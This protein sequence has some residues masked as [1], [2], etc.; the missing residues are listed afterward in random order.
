MAKLKVGTAKSPPLRIGEW[1]TEFNGKIPRHQTLDG[2]EPIAV[3]DAHAA[4]VVDR[5]VYVVT[6]LAEDKTKGDVAYELYVDLQGKI[7]V[8]EGNHYD[9]IPERGSS[10]VGEATHTVRLPRLNPERKAIW[11]WL[12]LSPFRLPKPAVHDLEQLAGDLQK[13]V[14]PLWAWSRGRALPGVV[15]SA[16]GWSL[17]ETPLWLTVPPGLPDQGTKCRVALGIDPFTLAE[18]RSRTYVKA[19]NR[20]K[21]EYEPENPK[22][23]SEY[24]R[25]ALGRLITQTVLG[26]ETSADKYKEYLD[27]AKLNAAMA[28]DDEVRNKRIRAS[29]EAAAAMVD[30]MDSRLFDLLVQAS[31]SDE[32]LDEGAPSYPLQ[33]VYRVLG[34]CTRSLNGSAAGR[35][36]LRDWADRADKHSDHFINHVIL[37]KKHPSIPRFKAFRWGSKAI[38]S[39]L[40]QYLSHHVAS[41]R[42]KIIA[43][44]AK[45]FEFELGEKLGRLAGKATP[46]DF[47]IQ[48]KLNFR[49]VS[50]QVHLK[51]NVGRVNV[52]EIEMPFLHAGESDWVEKW[53][54]AGEFEEFGVGA[55]FKNAKFLGSLLLDTV[56][57][58]LA[59]GAVRDADSES[60]KLMA[61]GTITAHSMNLVSAIGEEYAKKVLK[62]R[63]LRVAQRVFF[64]ARGATGAFF[65]AQN[66]IAARKAESK[67]DADRALALRVA[68][69]AEVA[70]AFGCILSAVAVSS[71]A[72]PWISVI[73]GL[74][75]AGAY[76]A[77]EI[78]TDDDLGIFLSHCE[79]GADPY[80]NPDLEPVWAS[81]AVGGWQG[82]YVEQRRLLLKL[83]TKFSV[84]WE[85]HGFSWLGVRVNLSFVTPESVLEVKFISQ[86]PGQAQVEDDITLR[87]DKL[88]R[89]FPGSVTVRPEQTVDGGEPPDLRAVVTFRWHPDEHADTVVFHLRVGGVDQPDED[90]SSVD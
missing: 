5:W 74:V 45:D 55:K 64:A 6:Q 39:V 65:A 10:L 26:S 87:V 51:Y 56:N 33:C 80:S 52:A 69:G 88:P 32:G 42:A 60:A 63:S 16:D 61:A 13:H 30:V 53:I 72:G 2:P 8:T 31:L 43:P 40:A 81:L 85:S 23:G 46:V 15:H 37:P 9:P 1:T 21:R 59:V 86:R 83:L 27:I 11:M 66:E 22:P 3:A 71:A 36:L 62:E 14:P 73:A 67:G 48:R 35:A 24:Q 77:A 18:V 20:Y 38:A 78:L 57:I 19:Y 84:G 34:W 75:A 28:A 25:I 70:G 4:L 90:K 54:D 44:V 89:H 49:S 29:E 58:A 12:F 7:W 47:T 50:K 17:E 76:I 41:L 82:D 79:W 68:A